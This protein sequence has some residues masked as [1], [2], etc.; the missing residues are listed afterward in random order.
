MLQQIVLRELAALSTIPAAW[1]IREPPTIVAGLADV[2]VGALGLDFA[3]VRMHDPQGGAPIEVTRGHASKTFSE[4]V[5]TH[6]GA[7][8]Q[9]SRKQ[10]VTD[11]GSAEPCRGVVIPI[12]VNSERG[13][14]AAACSRSDF[15]NKIDHL[16]LGVAANHAA[17]AFQN[18]RLRA[19][20]D[21]KV[22]ELHQARNEL[23][24]KVVERTV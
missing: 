2:L 22:A 23:E 11:L 7:V 10:I 3:F 17:T 20:L 9:F 15:P 13:L 18:A 4:W 8:D 1:A 21:A 12:G 19:E 24:I 16:L 6:L 14:V 5:R